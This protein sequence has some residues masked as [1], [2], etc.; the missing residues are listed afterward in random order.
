MINF[1][2]GLQIYK[3]KQLESTF[4]EVVQEEDNHRLPIQTFFYGTL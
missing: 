3:F 1:K 2:K 4:T